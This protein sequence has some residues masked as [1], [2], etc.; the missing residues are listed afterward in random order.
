MTVFSVGQDMAGIRD[1]LTR[2]VAVGRNPQRL[3]GAIGLGLE[4]STRE[5]MRDGVDPDG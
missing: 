4:S 2:M 3:L 1:A 5:R